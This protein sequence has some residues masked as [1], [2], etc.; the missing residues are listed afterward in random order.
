M[1]LW[2]RGGENSGNG[3]KGSIDDEKKKATATMFGKFSHLRVATSSI[4]S[5]NARYGTAL[6]YSPALNCT[7]LT[8]DLTDQI[9]ESWGAF[10]GT[11]ATVG[12]LDPFQVV[13]VSRKFHP[14]LFWFLELKSLISMTVSSAHCHEEKLHSPKKT[15]IKNHLLSKIWK[16]DQLAFAEQKKTDQFAF[17]KKTGP[18]VYFP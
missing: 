1:Q 7:E 15:G 5:A 10:P 4:I 11:A 14:P 17:T 8:S 13:W 6:Y 12:E 16:K 18:F 9:A 2:R 3:R